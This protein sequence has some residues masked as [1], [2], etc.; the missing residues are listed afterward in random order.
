MSARPSLRMI[1]EPYGVNPHRNAE[2]NNTGEEDKDKPED[3][4]IEGE[5]G[6][7]DHASA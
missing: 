2:V 7:I 5:A 3:I 4:R 6:G 1:I